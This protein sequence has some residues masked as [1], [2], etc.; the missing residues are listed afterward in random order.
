MTE[1]L[2]LREIAPG[3]QQDIRPDGLMREDPRLRL[4][5]REAAPGRLP[6]IDPYGIIF[7]W[8]GRLLRAWAG[9]SARM[10]RRVLASPALPGLFDAGLVRFHEA[11]VELEG[12][13]LVLEVDRIPFISYP[14]EWPAAMVRQAGLTVARLAHDLAASGCGLVD[15]HLFNIVFDGSRAVFVDVGSVWEHP[16][17]SAPWVEEFRMFNLVPLALRRARLHGLAETVQGVDSGW[18]LSL[19]G[20]RGLR[21]LPPDYAV[22]TRRRS[23]QVKYLADLEQYM[24]RIPALG[25]ARRGHD[26]QAPDRDLSPEKQ[27]VAEGILAGI[28]PGSVMDVGTGHGWLALA[29]ARRGNRVVATDLDELALGQLFLRAAAEQLPVLPLRIDVMRPAGSWGVNLDCRPAPDRLAVDTVFALSM[30]HHLAATQRVT[31]DLFAGAVNLFARRRAVVEF[32]PRDDPTVAD[33]PLAALSWYT[34]ENFVDAMAP[35]F[36]LVEAVPAAA[37]RTILVFERTV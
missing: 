23:D 21:W 19:L 18:L 1:R 29:A 27:R 37:Q 10:M 3:R 5:L 33:G 8:V 30:L 20:R 32:V 15:A 13:D 16:N 25:F 22:M 2:T 34:M 7:E 24:A 6:S 9:E 14:S 11:N 4:T 12:Y 36:R 35:F 28:G 31:F 26:E 17:T